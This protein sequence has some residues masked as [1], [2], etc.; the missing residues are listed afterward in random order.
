MK[1]VNMTR[2]YTHELTVAVVIHTRLAQGWTL[3]QVIMN[4]EGSHEAPPLREAL[5][6]IHGWRKG[7]LFSSAVHY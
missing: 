4:G 7:V 3:A 2:H 6:I 5:L 1:S